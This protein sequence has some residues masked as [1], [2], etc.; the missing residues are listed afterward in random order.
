MWQKWQKDELWDLVIGI[1]CV[2]AC[3][4][5]LLRTNEPKTE[6]GVC[7]ACIAMSDPGEMGRLGQLGSP[8]LKAFCTIATVRAAHTRSTVMN[9]ILWQVLIKKSYGDKQ[10]WQKR[11]N[12]GIF[13]TFAIMWQKWQKDELWIFATFAI[14]WQKWQK[15]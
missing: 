2:N 13:A 6:N 8:H 7:C 11:M 3:M 15:G 1:Q 10:K 14:M 12:Y 4:L 5:T 9:S